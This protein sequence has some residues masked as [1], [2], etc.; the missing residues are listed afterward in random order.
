MKSPVHR[1]L[2]QI[3]FAFILLTGS[4]VAVA[5][6][7]IFLD[8]PGIPGE[9]LDA[10]Y[11]GK[12]DVLSWGQSASNVNTGPV[13]LP[14]TVS[15]YTD[16]ASPLLTRYVLE[17]TSIPEMRVIVRSIGP[18][19]LEYLIVKLCNANV[20]SIKTGG[21]ATDTRLMETVTFSAAAYNMAYTQLNPDGSITGPIIYE[22]GS[23][24][25]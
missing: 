16:I 23:C 10:T 25:Y 9:S 20:I 12:I 21:S 14:L 15:K 2:Q 24:R 13:L 22:Y 17:G 18:N 8:I 3:F 7:E 1:A 19:P 5:A 11:A 6:V 4:Q